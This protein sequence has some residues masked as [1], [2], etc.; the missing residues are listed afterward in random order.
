LFFYRLN[1]QLNKI[2]GLALQ[3]RN[4]Y[5][6]VQQD[7]QQRSHLLCGKRPADAAGFLCWTGCRT[8]FCTPGGCS[9]PKSVDTGTRAVIF[10]EDAN[11]KK[12]FLFPSAATTEDQC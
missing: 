2:N 1:R 9:E 11:V 3:L 4:S 12:Y 7:T 5:I 10:K 8:K 6:F